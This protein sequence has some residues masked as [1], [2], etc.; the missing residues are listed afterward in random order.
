MLDAYSGAPLWQ[1]RWAELPAFAQ[2]TAVGI[3]FHRG[4]FGLWNQALLLAFGLGLPVSTATGA[5]MAVARWRRG[6]VLL[7]ELRSRQ[8]LGWRWPLLAASLLLCWLIPL[9]AAFLL[10]V[11]A[12][13]WRAAR[14]PVAAG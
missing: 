10:I 5:L 7:P 9:L 1:S 12:V 14:A 2:A 6:Q 13:E 11:I 8:G 4:E 3:P